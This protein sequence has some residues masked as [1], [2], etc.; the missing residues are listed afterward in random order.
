MLLA[1]L[2]VFRPI[3]GPGS[4][5]VEQTAYAE[6]FSGS[7]VPA[8]PVPGARGLVSED[9]VQPV[10]VLGRDRRVCLAFAVAVIRPPRVIAALGDA[11][12]FAGEHEA[13]RTIEQLWSAVHA[14]PITVAILD[15]AHHP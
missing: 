7:A 6:L 11:A 2:D 9:A 10:A 8:G 15:V 5:V 13:I 4:L 12:M 14:L 3:A 1:S